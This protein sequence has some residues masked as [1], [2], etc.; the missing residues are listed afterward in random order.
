[1]I[2]KDEGDDRIAA[3]IEETAS[4]RNVKLEPGEDVTDL[5]TKYPGATFE[6]LFTLPAE[7]LKELSAVKPGLP[8]MTLWFRVKRSAADADLGMDAMVESLEKDDKIAHVEI[9]AVLVPPP[10]PQA[11]SWAGGRRTQAQAISPDFISNQTYLGPASNNGIDAEYSWNF[12]GGDGEGV[13]IYDVEYCWTQDHE[14]LERARD[15]QL[16]LDDGDNSV[17][18]FFNASTPENCEHGTGVLGV[19]IATPNN[20]VG[21]KGISH[22]ANVGLAPDNTEKL[23]SNRA[24]SI[25]L[26]VDDGKPGDVILLEI[27]DTVCGNPFPPKGSQLG[28]GPAEGRLSVFEATQVAVGN[29]IIV[30]ATAGN[31]NV[32]LDDPA[33]EDKYNREVRDSGAIMVGAGGSGSP[34]CSPACTKM[35]FST[36]GSRLDVQGWG[37]SHQQDMVPYTKILKISMIIRNG[38]LIVFLEH[39]VLALSSPALLQTFKALQ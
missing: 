21:M 2:E 37:A 4:A 1:M 11:V 22:G 20:G 19:M 12:P 8:D 24:N 17:D 5:E 18:P 29:G 7:R 33:C 9:P 14:D 32:N 15:V 31:G 34:G 13:T 3:I 16:L 6:P 30:V 23:G 35:D 26:A 10:Q 28:F 38:I 36:H 39:L 25:L 27:Q